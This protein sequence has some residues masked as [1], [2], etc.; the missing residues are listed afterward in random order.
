[1]SNDNAIKD[2]NKLSENQDIKNE[3]NKEDNDISFNQLLNLQILIQNHS[4]LKELCK[5]ILHLIFKYL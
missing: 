2:N 1:M 3:N 4:G 5:F